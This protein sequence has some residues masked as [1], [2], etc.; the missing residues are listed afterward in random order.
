M[1]I[2]KEHK[3]IYAHHSEVC[4]ITNY[5]MH[6]TDPNER[7]SVHFVKGPNIENRDGTAQCQASH[8][9]P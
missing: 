4:Q 5:L 1:T 6:C 2:D 3:T 8:D 7:W 9:K